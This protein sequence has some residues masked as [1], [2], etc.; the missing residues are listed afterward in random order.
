MEAFRLWLNQ[1]PSTSVDAMSPRI[2]D[3][4]KT[5][6]K[7]VLSLYQVDKIKDLPA[8]N[9]LDLAKAL[10]ITVPGPINP[11][12]QLFAEEFPEPAEDFAEAGTAAHE[13]IETDLSKPSRPYTPGP[14]QA[15]AERPFC[16]NGMT[17]PE[18]DF[19]SARDRLNAKREEM[20][21]KAV[22]RWKMEKAADE[23]GEY[24][25]IVAAYK[26]EST[27]LVIFQG[28]MS[29]DWHEAFISQH[30]DAHMRLEPTGMVGKFAE[31]RAN[32]VRVHTGQSKADVTVRIIFK[33][34]N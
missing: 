12:S 25:T 2:N 32:A 24:F 29:D 17:D 34:T 31:V 27:F 18:P 3:L 13:Q 4:R 16:R 26:P 15:I 19:V 22:A 28:V 23:R 14:R 7:S 10:G 9:Q 21:A 1:Y 33:K 6:L 30:T 8:Q 20:K 11:L 5:I